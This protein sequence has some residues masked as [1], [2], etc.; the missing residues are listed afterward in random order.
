VHYVLKKCKPHG[1][2]SAVS[3]YQAQAA[4]AGLLAAP[5]RKSRRNSNSGKTTIVFRK[6]QQTARTAP[7]PSAAAAYEWG[8]TARNRAAPALVCKTFVPDSALAITNSITKLG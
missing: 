2:A 6:Q 5:P 3:N 4:E 8:D 7:W 1:L